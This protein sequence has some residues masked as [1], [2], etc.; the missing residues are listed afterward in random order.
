MRSTLTKYPPGSLR[1]FSALS[2]PLILIL[3]A[4]GLMELCDRAFLSRLS[5]NFLHGSLNAAYLCRIFQMPTMRIALMGQIFTAFYK[6]EDNMKHIGSCIWQLI[7]FSFISMIVIIPCGLIAGFF[8][9]KG[10]SIA[11]AGGLYFYPLL[12]SNF[13]FPLG[14][15]LSA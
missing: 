12:L 1:E 5:M 6:G 4:G 13:L 11:D 2:L 10:T 14:G 9:F 3:V 15:A 7:W 8:F